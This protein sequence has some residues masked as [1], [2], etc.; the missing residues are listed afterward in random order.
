MYDRANISNKLL[1]VQ[2]GNAE[3][4]TQ[5]LGILQ[6][7][8]DLFYITLGD[9]YIEPAKL[10]LNTDSKPFNCKYYPV[11]G[12]N[13]ET[14]CKELQLLVKIGVLTPVQ[15]SQY[16]TSIFN[17]YEKEGTI[18]FITDYRRLNHKLVRNMYILP[19]IGNKM[20]QLEG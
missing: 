10:E 14:F 12:V 8:E 17:I 6:Y 2:G 13:K 7:F 11:L 1:Y 4:R 3:E 19:I 5:L 9:W 16:S 18:G 20:Q 15:Q